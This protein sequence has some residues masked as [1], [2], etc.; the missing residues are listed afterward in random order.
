MLILGLIL[1]LVGAL[2]F[3]FLG[4]EPLVRFAGGVLIV[5]GLFLVALGVLDIADVD[6]RT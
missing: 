5:I 3:Y 4:P 1:I 2:V 6:V